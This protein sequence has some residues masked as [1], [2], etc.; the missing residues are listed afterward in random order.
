MTQANENMQFDDMQRRVQ[1]IQNNFDIVFNDV[2]L[3]RKLRRHDL[4]C[5]SPC[6]VISKTITSKVGF[7]TETSRT[8]ALSNHRRLENRTKRIVK[9]VAYILQ[10]QPKD[11][12]VLDSNGKYVNGKVDLGSCTGY[13]PR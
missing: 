13:C 3:I 6:Q 4:K 5:V 2:A 10:K 9:Q 12:K 7:Q 11:I 1:A 8:Q